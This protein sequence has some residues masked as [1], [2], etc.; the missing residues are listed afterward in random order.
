MEKKSVVTIVI[1][2]LLISKIIN[3]EIV[4]LILIIE[5]GR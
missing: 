5:D 1:Q 3:K 4:K 2:V